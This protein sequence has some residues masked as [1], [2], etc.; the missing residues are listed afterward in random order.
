MAS[1][2]GNAFTSAA[3][4]AANRTTGA[5]GANMLKASGD[6]RLDAFL[7][8]TQYSK[9]EDIDRT[10]NELIKQCDHVST[11]DRGLYLADIWRLMVHKRQARTGERTRHL[12][13]RMFFILY[14]HSPDLVRW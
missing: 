10:V 14:E 12:G 9:D 4:G 3:C 5:K 11:E 8:L 2:A 1:N 6:I 7:G 13:R